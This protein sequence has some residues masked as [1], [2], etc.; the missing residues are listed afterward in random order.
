MQTRSF[1]QCGHTSTK[2]I[3]WVRIERPRCHQNKEEPR[4]LAV[5]YDQAPH[6]HARLHG[7]TKPVFGVCAAY[8]SMTRLRRRLNHRCGILC[9]RIRNSCPMA[10][11]IVHVAMP[12]IRDRNFS[13]LCREVIARSYQSSRFKFLPTANSTGIFVRIYMIPAFTSSDLSGKHKVSLSRFRL[14]ILCTSS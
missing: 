12:R 6:S 4:G 11:L 14:N 8:T 7:K 9:Q 5:V 2:P 10:I 13:T 3:N 1:D